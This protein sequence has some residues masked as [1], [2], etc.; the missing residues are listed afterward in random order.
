MIFDNF[1]ILDFQQ[2]KYKNGIFTLAVDWKRFL[3][4]WF[5]DFLLRNGKY[6]AYAKY[7]KKVN[8]RWN[9]KHRMTV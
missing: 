2:K 8:K 5:N 6:E 9:A 1:H 7:S 3:H 4:H